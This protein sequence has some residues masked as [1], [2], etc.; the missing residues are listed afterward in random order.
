MQIQVNEPFFELVKTFFSPQLCKIGNGDFLKHLAVF[1]PNVIGA[2]KCT[3]FEITRMFEIYRCRICYSSSD[4]QGLH[5]RKHDN[6]LAHPDIQCVVEKQKPI[7]IR[8]PL[9]HKK[10]AYFKDLIQRNNINQI[11]YIPILVVGEEK[12]LPSHKI[13]THIFV[14]DNEKKFGRQEIMLARKISS[15]I[16]DKIQYDAEILK[17]AKEASLQ[18]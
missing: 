4:P 12:S 2:K 1:L 7:L 14:L 8:K 17:F 3:V 9:K 11:L 13:V 15:W 16:S 10:T 6:L 5:A 18:G